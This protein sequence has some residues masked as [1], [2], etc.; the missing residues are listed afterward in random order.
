MLVDGGLVRLDLW[1]GQKPPGEGPMKWPFVRQDRSDYRQF[2]FIL[3][4]VGHPHRE[5]QH[6][7]D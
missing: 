2:S 4:T 6:R 7:G 5:M 3:A 1:L